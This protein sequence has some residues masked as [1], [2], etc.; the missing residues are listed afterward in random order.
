MENS[1]EFTAGPLKDLVR[2]DFQKMDAWFEEDEQ[3]FVHPKDPYK[4]IDIRRSSRHIRVEVHG[5]V[6]AETS[7]PTLLFETGLRTRYY[8]PPTC[9]NQTML[10]RS[11][12]VTSCP[13]KGDASYYNIFI[14]GSNVDFEVEDA[15]WWYKHPTQESL[16][17]AGLF[18][19]YNEKVDIWVDGVKEP[20]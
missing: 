10:T 3:I 16:P 20:K 17:I 5:V 14:D 7:S 8:L 15:I 19:F 2:F 4:R 12:T 11:E 6:I 18:C 9:V 13:Y 1:I